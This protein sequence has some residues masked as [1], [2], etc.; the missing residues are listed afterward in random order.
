MIEKRLAQWYASDTGVDL[1]IVEREIALTYV[2]RILSDHGLLECL[3]FKGGTAIRKLFLGSQGRFSLD[4]DFTALGNTNAEDLILE[5]VGTLHGK[6]YYGLDFD[7]P[8]SDYY[9]S[10]DSCG[11]EVTYRHSWTN[12]SRFGI[13]I[14]LRAQPLLPVQPMQ[15]HR[16]RY[17]EW[18]GVEPPLVPT[19]DLHEIIGEKIRAAAQRSRVRDI[20]DL[21]QL[22]GQK[23]DRGQVRRIAIIK[24]WETSFAFTPTTFWKNLMS[25]R[26]DWGDLRRL[27]RHGRK[28]TPETI[29]NGVQKEYAF[30]NEMTN[31][32]EVLAADAHRREHRTYH[33]LVD[34]LHEALQ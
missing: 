7:I 19:L 2:L 21:Y 28:L 30:L 4:L 31:E 11:A 22:A 12:K 8:A 15:L 1:D 16:E 13:Q 17:F 3:A 24:C 14:S 26:Y 20:Y 34:R 25:G 27:I 32:E 29:L 23:F 18:I 9:V 6:T 33:W 5:I 10:P